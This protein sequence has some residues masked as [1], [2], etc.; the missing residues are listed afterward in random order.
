[1]LA[2]NCVMGRYRGLMTDTD[3]EYIANPEDIEE[4]KRH[5]AISRV[6][7]RI[8]EEMPQDV[9]ILQEHHPGLLDELR[10]AVCEDG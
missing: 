2:D 6:R 3:R 4:N 1:M 9:E 8:T 7:K 10:D 5:Q